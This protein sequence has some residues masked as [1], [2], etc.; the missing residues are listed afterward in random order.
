MQRVHEVSDMLFKYSIQNYGKIKMSQ[1]INNWLKDNNIKREELYDA[2]KFMSEHGHIEPDSRVGGEYKTT[3]IGS[4]F[5]SKNGW[6]GYFKH[7][8]SMAEEE[9]EVKKLTIDLTKDQLRTN[10]VN[11]IGTFTALLISIASLIVAVKALINS[12]P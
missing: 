11:R 2:I 1:S 10:K 9:M 12:K 5:A 7:L 8:K 6:C 3:V 4:D